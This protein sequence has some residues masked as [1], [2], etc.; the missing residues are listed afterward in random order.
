MAG[1]E[2]VLVSDFVDESGVTGVT[3]RLKNDGGVLGW[4][5]TSCA[6]WFLKVLVRSSD[7]GDVNELVRCG[8]RSATSIPE[9][10][11]L[12]DGACVWRRRRVSRDVVVVVTMLSAFG[13]M[14]VRW[15]M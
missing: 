13:E 11:G 9:R 4:T 10:A 14:T 3:T 1:E 15:R 5:T 6:F 8:A 12:D 2:V 7:C